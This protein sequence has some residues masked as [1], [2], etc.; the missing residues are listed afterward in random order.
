MSESAIPKIDC[1]FCGETLSKNQYYHHLPCDGVEPEPAD[2]GF[3][4]PAI[5]ATV[6]D[7]DG[8][9]RLVVVETY[10]TAEASNWNVPELDATVGDVN[11]N[12]DDRAPVVEGVYVDD[13]NDT[14]GEW[15]D[16]D[17]LKAAVQDDRLDAYHF[18]SGRLAQGNG[19]YKP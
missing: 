13:V 6:V 14:V 16:V 1:P 5:G 8:G 12:Y 18:P 9:D 15:D 7:R 4:L 10:P 19:V 11:P 17:D 2:G 3:H